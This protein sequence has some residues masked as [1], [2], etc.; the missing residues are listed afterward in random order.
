MAQASQPGTAHSPTQ[1]PARSL[2][3]VCYSRVHRHPSARYYRLCQGAAC[4]LSAESRPM[5]RWPGATVHESQSVMSRAHQVTQPS[6]HAAC[7]YPHAG[8]SP[9]RATPRTPAHRPAALRGAA[10]ALTLC[11]AVRT[12][13]CISTH[14]LLARSLGRGALPAQHIGRRPLTCSVP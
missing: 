1:S 13:G 10:V 12:R 2:P 7:S 14:R 6:C 3:F 4:G 11:T 9:P 5:G 8:R